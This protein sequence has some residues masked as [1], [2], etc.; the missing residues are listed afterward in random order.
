VDPSRRVAP[1]GLATSRGTP[2]TRRAMADNEFSEEVKREAWRLAGY[3]CCFCRDEQG[4]DVHHLRTQG[5]KAV[6][7]RAADASSAASGFAASA[8]KS[9]QDADEYLAL[10]RSAP[11]IAQRYRVPTRAAA[12]AIQTIQNAVADAEAASGRA[13]AAAQLARDA[14]ARAQTSAQSAAQAKDEGS[15]TR[16]AREA[17]ATATEADQAS[18]TASD[19]LKSTK[20]SAGA[21]TRGLAAL[22]EAAKEASDRGTQQPTQARDSVFLID[23][24]PP[25]TMILQSSK[26]SRSTRCLNTR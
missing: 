24:R 14:A 12:D 4:D 5:L 2:H 8:A 3:R 21:A 26:P 20:S 25:L 19:E 15:A 18:K 23:V 1:W 9:A 13:H 17:A 10:V 16:A 6:V 7:A 22:R 11:A